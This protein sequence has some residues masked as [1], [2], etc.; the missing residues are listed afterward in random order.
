[1]KALRER[2]TLAAAKD[3]LFLALSQ[4][5]GVQC[6][7][8]EQHVRV[9]RRVL[10]STIAGPL[11]DIYTAANEAR[12]AYR[13]ASDT[14]CPHGVP[15]RAPF[16]CP[17]CVPG[18]AFPELPPNAAIDV[19][20]GY[21]DVRRFGYRGGDYSKGTHWGLLTPNVFYLTELGVAFVE[22][23]TTA[24]SASPRSAPT[25]RPRSG[26]RSRSTR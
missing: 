15:M 26:P 4:G 1:M 3:A 19:V 8:C 23:K 18:R 7:C 9:W 25:S 10:G 11:K 12:D 16:S 21:V 6:P 17:S 24:S 2:S 20:I 22:G 14:P 5:S 13:A